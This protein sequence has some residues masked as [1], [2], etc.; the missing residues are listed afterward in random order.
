MGAMGEETFAREVRCIDLSDLAN[1]KE[2]IADELWRA[3]V[4]I[5]FFQVSHHG[6]ALDDIRQAFSMTEAFFAL[7]GEI[8]A[9]YPLSRNA[10]WENKSQV[11]PSTQ[12][13]DQKESYQIT[14]PLMDPLWPAE[15]E[16]PAFKRTMLNFESQCW[17]LG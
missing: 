9:R 4:E 17:Q 1:R 14:R 11:R 6:I 5:G 12:T 7:P 10:G 15:H 8:K 13:P 16:L 2:E 3:A